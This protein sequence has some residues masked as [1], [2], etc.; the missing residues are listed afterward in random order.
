MGISEESYKDLGKLKIGSQAP[1][2][3]AR[4]NKNRSFSLNGAVAEGDVVL[5]FYRGHWCPYCTKYLGEFVNR[6]E[7]LQEKGVQVVAVAPEGSKYQRELADEFAVDIPFI[8]DPKGEIMK[9]YKVAFTVNDQYNE[10]FAKWKDGK[11]LASVNGQD[12]AML[13]IPAT[14]LIGA[15]RKIKYAYFN[16]DYSKRPDIDQIINKL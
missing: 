9:L 13:P 12:E 3:I 6:F 11:S 10:K 8:S 15:D 14:Y 1:N 5:I 2:F 4:D 7:E 16:P